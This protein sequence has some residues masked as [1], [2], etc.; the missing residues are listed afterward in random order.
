MLVPAGIGFL[1]AA[2]PIGTTLALN[3][4]QLAAQVQSLL[5]RKG[6][7]TIRWG[8][9]V[10]RADTGEVL[11]SYH[12]DALLLPASNRKLF[13]TALALDRLG[14]DYRF[15]TPLYLSS[16][17]DEHGQ[18]RGD[19]IV[20]GTGDPTFLNPRFHR[21][22]M[23]SPFQEWIEILSR[24][25]VRE[26]EGD[27]VMDGSGFDSGERL[28]EGWIKDYET[29]EYAPRVSAICIA[30]NRVAVSVRPAAQTGQPPSIS[31][32][33]ANSIVRIDNQAITG[34][35]RCADTI[36]IGRAETGPDHL[37]VRGRIARTAGEQ[38]QR[39][40]LEQPGLVAGEVFRSLLEKKA[41]AV[42]GSVRAPNGE[43]ASSPTSWV[44]VA[45]YQSPP[46]REI[47]ALTNK[48]SDNYCAEQLF[49]AVAFAKTGRASYANAKKYE[50]EFLAEVGILPDAANFEDGCGLSRL[51][52]V[53]PQAVVRL[54]CHMAGHK[55]ATDFMDSLAVAGRDG[56]LAGRMG[57]RAQGRVRAKTGLLSMASCLSGYAQTRSGVTVAFSILANDCA[58]RSS[59]ATAIQD[60]IC[61]SLVNTSF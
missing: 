40:P 46:L 18:V 47:I 9:C 14:P 60:R 3:R 28:A 48:H 26:I 37:I 52:L 44:A 49:Q 15:T 24:Q 16:P 17:A 22:S 38:S 51:N 50:E 2:A 8:V 34:P 20:R 43:H 7:R 30:G 35:A 53:S 23:I 6:A 1:L 42:R 21:G 19:L 25:G 29:A 31:L 5:E 11:F 33:P 36:E 4:A 57:R 32:L 10:A 54:L 12:S 58:G 55:Y 13:V 27:L 59:E 45:K 61:E 41:I 39:V 56:T